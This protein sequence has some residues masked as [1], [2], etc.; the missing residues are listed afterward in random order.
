[1]IKTIHCIMLGRKFFSNLEEVCIN[2][3]KRI[4]PD[5]EIKIWTDENTIQWIKES[6]FASHHN[7]NTKCMAFVSDYLRCKILYE[8]GGL[9]MDCDVYAVERIPDRYFNKSFIPWDSYGVTTNNG[10][11]FY[12]PIPKLPI[13]KEFCDCMKDNT[14]LEVKNSLATNTLINLVLAKRGFDFD[15]RKCESDIDLGDIMILNRAQFGARHTDSNGYVTYGKNI[16]LIHCC[17]GSWTK[18]LFSGRVNLMYAIINEYTDINELKRRLNKLI[19]NKTGASCFVL[20]LACRFEFDEELFN[21]VKDLRTFTTCII[22]PIQGNKNSMA[23][24]FLTRRASNIYRCKNI[25]RGE[26]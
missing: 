10:T 21:M 3:W 12:A 25:M 26:I 5:F 15:P 22:P 23:L 7:F 2:S 18:H 4:Y 14:A 1:M 17:F 24:E 6:S 9:Y 20:L 16:Y 8:E 13:F 11:C 19:K